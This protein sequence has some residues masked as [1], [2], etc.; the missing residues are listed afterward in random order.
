VDETSKAQRAKPR[1]E[2]AVSNVGIR[3]PTLLYKEAKH[4]AVDKEI[5][6]GKVLEQA[7]TEYL[8][9]RGRKVA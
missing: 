2:C 9:A 6:L 5:S 1:E 7:V 4:Y 8:A 3:L